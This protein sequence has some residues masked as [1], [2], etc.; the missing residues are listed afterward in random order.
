MY[1]LDRP[2]NMSTYSVRVAADKAAFPVLLSNGNDVESGELAGGRHFVR[3]DD[4]WPKPCYLF[5]L[6][7]G[8]FDVLRDSFTTR[9]GAEVALGVHVEKGC[10]DQTQHC[11]ASLKKAMRWDEDRFD[12]EYDLSCFNIV[13][14]SDF[15]M[16]AMENKV[17]VLLSLVASLHFP[18]RSAARRHHT[19]QPSDHQKSD[20]LNYTSCRG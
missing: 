12:R 20:K 4:P 9:G 18:H 3:Y 7:A 6:V 1:F 14:V 10:L 13:A 11:M 16:G 8:D 19:N 17:R 2:D 5:A 15:N